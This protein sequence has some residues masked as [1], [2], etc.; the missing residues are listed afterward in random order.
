MMH[1]TIIKPNESWNSVIKF[2]GTLFIATSMA[3]SVGTFN[4]TS[5]AATDLDAGAGQNQSSD[6]QFVRLALNKSAV[7][8]LPT[9][10]Y[11]VVIGESS[12]VDA[13]LRKKDT[14]YLFAK[15]V[16]QT[17]VFFFDQ[18]GNQIMALD[19]EVVRD[20]LPL[21]KMLQRHIPGNRITV[22]NAESNIILGGTAR[23]P[24]EATLA[25]KLAEQYVGTTSG[26]GG[27][28]AAG[29]VSPIVNAMKVAGENQV[30]LKVKVVEIQ[31]DVLKQLG[32]DLEAALSVGE[33][34]FSAATINPFSTAL[35]SPAAGAQAI[36]SS[37]ST[38]FSSIIR[39]MEKDG[40]SK[41][42]A[43]PNLTAISGQTA[44]FL[45]GGEFGYR[46]IV[47]GTAAVAFKPFG[48]GLQFTPTVL[49]D[50]RIHLKIKTEVSEIGDLTDGIP[51][52]TTR[53]AETALEAP[54]GGS[55]MIAGLI[56][57]NT[58][59]SISGMPGLKKL[60]V[61]GTLFR[62]RDF[63]SNETE[64]LIIVTP[65]LVKPTNEK[66]LISP[67]KNFAPSTD[68]QAIFMGKLHK[69]F[70]TSG[71]LEPGEYQGSVGYIVE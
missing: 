16:G 13:V 60:P 70:N 23:N 32:I 63:Q 34:V 14:V 51:A 38:R 19:F 20:P 44:N 48:V 54:S 11:D 4:I 22:D 71:K 21:K 68:K 39:A 41:T 33:T 42:L 29:S 8:K 31:R 65:Y 58:R 1:N 57:E 45:A 9:D 25:I 2:L 10:A 28:G 17:N 18:E 5:A 37:G 24:E 12:I 53:R 40:L 52:V 27:G 35:L 3:V 26:G 7:I 43:E 64:L 67:D 50:N 56:R 55:M 49:N 46:V 47:D 66:N 62:S 61:L 36:D 15:T 6:N 59:Q 30:M 69:N